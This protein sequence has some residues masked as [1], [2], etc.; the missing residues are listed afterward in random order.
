MARDATPQAPSPAGAA[1]GTAAAAD[2]PAEA[3]APRSAPQSS[4]GLSRLASVSED[5][6]LA[7]MEA[8]DR[9]KTG[10]GGS[11]TG[12]ATGGSP[13]PQLPAAGS[14]SAFGS[15][16]L[17]LMAPRV[18]NG[19]GSER[20]KGA[21]P[22]PGGSAVT[23]PATLRQRMRRAW[24]SA[25]HIWWGL[26]SACKLTMV[27][28]G[29]H[30]FM[31]FPAVLRSLQCAGMRSPQCAAGPA[32]VGLVLSVSATVPMVCLAAPSRHAVVNFCISCAY[33]IVGIM[34]PDVDEEIHIS[35]T[36]IVSLCRCAAVL[37][38]LSAVGGIML[39]VV[40][41]QGRLA[42]Q[43]TCRLAPTL[44]PRRSPLCLSC[45]AWWMP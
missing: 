39:R 26:P 7:H 12:S 32:A 45:S 34:L 40:Q 31:S 10:A 44:H 16:S 15:A 8:G 11:A 38:C 4:R 20:G 33:A 28:A 23:A 14:V 43:L 22:S 1:D 42:A 29:A 5:S 36:I 18:E 27:L 9:G 24:A 30:D 13:P 17:S 6:E 3:G 19:E 35:I 2:A 37:L 21:P 25:M 41:R